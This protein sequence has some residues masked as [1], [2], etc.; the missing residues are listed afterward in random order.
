ME[1]NWHKALFLVAWRATLQLSL[2]Y[3]DGKQQLTYK[4][5]F[6]VA[7]RATLQRS[8]KYLDGKQQLTYKAL[9]LVARRATIATE[10]KVCR[11]K[12][13][14]DIKALFL[15]ARRAT[16]QLSWKYVASFKGEN[17]KLC[18]LKSFWP[19]AP[20][21]TQLDYENDEHEVNWHKKLFAVHFN[22]DHGNKTQMEWN[23]SNPLK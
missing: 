1:S 13:A 8:W 5:L 12:A 18:N 22:L 16:L 20:C 3:L 21:Q 14:I 17:W 9:F 19:S 4:A 2:K 6:L 11:W 7:W 23:I 10:L 15:V